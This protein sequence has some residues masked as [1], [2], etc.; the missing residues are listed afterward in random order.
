MSLKDHR[1]ELNNFSRFS[2]TYQSNL[3][4]P[5]TN[6]LAQIE[7]ETPEIQKIKQKLD[8]IDE[9]TSSFI[10][11]KQEEQPPKSNYELVTTYYNKMPS[12][13]TQNQPS[14]QQSN[15]YK[16]SDHV[17]QSQ[18]QTTLQQT[19]RQKHSISNRSIVQIENDEQLKQEFQEFLL[20]KEFLK[21]KYTTLQD[22]QDLGQMYQSYVKLDIGEK[23]Q[24]YYQIQDNMKKIVLQK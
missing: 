18:L 23:L 10:N 7:I 12:N 20:F 9:M 1:E 11:I 3:V 4:Q 24:R 2:S 6:T 15:Y 21:A 17:P 16:L 19:K 5:Q 13:Y 22:N 14:N 8:R